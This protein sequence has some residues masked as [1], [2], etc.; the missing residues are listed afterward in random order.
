MTLQELL[1][2][3]PQ[4]PETSVPDWMLG[5]FRRHC[6][7]FA[8]GESDTETL[9][10]WFQ[11][12]NF[13][14]DL[15]LPNMSA[16]TPA[17]AL[18]DCS[19]ADL[20]M[21][22]SYQGWFAMSEWDGAMMNWHSETSL[23]LHNCWPE[24]AQLHRTGNCM[25]EFAPS[26]AYVEDWRLQPSAAGP[27]VGL[28]LLEERNM[29]TGK[30]E[31]RGGGLIICGD[32]AALV[33]GRARS[34]KQLAAPLAD[35]VA[36]ATPADVADLFAFE[37]SVARGTLELGYTVQHSTVAGRAGQPLLALHNADWQRDGEHILQT[38]KQNGEEI[39]LR[40]AI[41][42]LSAR[43]DFSQCSPMPESAHA[44]FAREAETLTRYTRPLTDIDLFKPLDVIGF[45]IPTVWQGQRVLL[46][47]ASPDLAE[48]DLEAVLS[49]QSALQQLFSRDDIWPPT[50]LTLSENTAD[51]AWHAEEFA[52]GRSFAYHLLDPY[53][54][55]CL[56]CLYIY[57][58]ASLAHDA[59]AYLWVRSDQE[60]QSAAAITQ[61]VINWL[62]T[63][64]HFRA[65]VWP[66]RSLSFEKWQDYQA[67]NYYHQYRFA[68]PIAP[69][70]PISGG[71]ALQAQTPDKAID[72]LPINTEVNHHE[73]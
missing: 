6:I 18:T 55:H 49:S 42:V 67:P 28:Q 27:L 51:L 41:D 20:Q 29:T 69:R 64:W 33:R 44:W 73:Y 60:P 70:R 54:Q 2:N 65:L 56:G 62:Q 17:L 37:T 48:A 7:S 63:Q 72:P 39:E 66:G 9:V 59:E 25:M 12:C 71:S 15:R 57:P 4:Q 21:L 22:A 50:N 52:A 24:P 19:P 31:H 23:Q 8:N 47:A 43:H 10:F 34:V 61:E 68:E 30:V 13:T 58:T 36:C 45:C 3:Y 16:R 1:K 38:L 11:S 46:M 5:C 26:G 35:A 40:F 32:Y 14:I 53:R